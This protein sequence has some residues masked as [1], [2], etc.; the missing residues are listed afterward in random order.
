[1]RALHAPIS[2]VIPT[3]N[4]GTYIDDA[5]ESV[6][7]QTV[8]PREIIIV[9]DASTDGTPDRVARL[10]ERSNVALRLIR[11]ETNSGSPARPM[12]AGIRAASGRLISV[13]DQDDVLLPSKLEQ[14]S[15]ILGRMEDVSFVFSLFGFLGKEWKNR[16][17]GYQWTARL[18][19]VMKASNGCY[20]CDGASA[21]DLF[22]KYENFVR[23]FPGFMFRRRDWREAQGFDESFLFTTDYDFLC[24]LCSRG[25]VA[26]IPETHY[27][28]REHDRNLTHSE[29]PRLIEIVRVLTTHICHDEM[30]A[31]KDY[32]RAL[33][34]KVLALARFLAGC[35]CAPQASQML[36]L[37]DQIRRTHIDVP[38]TRCR[39]AQ[40]AVIRAFRAWRKYAKMRRVTGEEATAA[41]E[42]VESLLADYGLLQPKGHREI[43]NHRKEPDRRPP[44]GGRTCPTK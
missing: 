13:L 44:H 10:A 1:M 29:V 17:I 8:C 39:H 22:V 40:L 27:L 31:R 12:N 38:H 19:R 25:S 11:R 9:D 5:L 41:V 26:F 3:Y 2:V 6:W 37:H 36:L 7:N 23:G 4:A 14:Q 21:F 33:A 30:A 43:G 32:R 24:W 20:R 28:R 34:S 16:I 42:N 35:G 18:A 15:S